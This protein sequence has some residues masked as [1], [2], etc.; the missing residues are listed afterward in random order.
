[1]QNSIILKSNAYFPATKSYFCEFA[2]TGLKNQLIAAGLKG[3]TVFSL[4]GEYLGRSTVPG[5]RKLR[6]TNE[7]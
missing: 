2:S 5:I 6:I 4:P 1:M 3:T 7:N